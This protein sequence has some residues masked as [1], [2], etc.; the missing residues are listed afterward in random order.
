MTWDKKGEDI[1]DIENNQTSGN[2][3]YIISYIYVY[4]YHMYI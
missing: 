2:N 3:W 4:I 1:V